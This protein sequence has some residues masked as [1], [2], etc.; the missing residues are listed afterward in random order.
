MSWPARRYAP[1][2]CRCRADDRVAPRAPAAANNCSAGSRPLKRRRGRRGKNH[3]SAGAR[4][5]RRTGW[6]TSCRRS[7]WD[8]ARNRRLGDAALQVVEQ[9]TDRGVEVRAAVMNR[10][11]PVD[12]RIQAQAGFGGRDCRARVG[13]CS[14][15]HGSMR[16]RGL[17]D[18]EQ[19]CLKFGSMVPAFNG[20]VL[21]CDGNGLLPSDDWNAAPG[22]SSQAAARR[23][24][25]IPPSSCTGSGRT[26]SGAGALPSPPRLRACSRSISP[27]C[28]GL[29]WTR[30][31]PSHRSGSSRCTRSS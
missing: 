13:R 8:T 5:A 12:D 14:W 18:R 31:H 3:R 23:P 9:V 16:H 20:L 15:H 30:A 25:T 26:E 28:S 1:P 17:T 21:D 2:R 4:R 10:S 6:S 22:W 29:C 11:H 7:P 24:D 19:A 27:C